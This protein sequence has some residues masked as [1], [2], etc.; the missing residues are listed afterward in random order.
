MRSAHTA[1]SRDAETE[2]KKHRITIEGVPRIVILAP[3]CALSTHTAAT[4]D[5]AID[6]KEQ[7]YASQLR[8]V[9]HWSRYAIMAA[10]RDVTTDEKEPKLHNQG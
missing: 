5:A 6:E 10:S 8:L 9:I 1:A 3:M 2:E 4:R 7:R